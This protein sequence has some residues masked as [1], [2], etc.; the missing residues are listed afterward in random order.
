MG[1]S[2]KD[3]IRHSFL[4]RYG[5]VGWLIVLN[6]GVFVISGTIL[7][8]LSLMGK[9]VWFHAVYDKLALPSSI[10]LFLSQPWSLFTYMWMHDFGGSALGA[11]F[12]ILFNMLWLYWIGGRIFK[13]YQPDRRIWFLFIVGALVGGLLFMAAFN[14]FPAFDGRLALLVGASAGVTAIMVAT[15]T[16]LPNTTMFLMF[17]GA[18]KLVWLV[19]IFLFIDFLSIAASG[20]PGGMIAHLGGALFGYLYMTGVKNGKDIGAPIFRLFQK[21]QARP[22]KSPLRVAT[23]NASGTA[24][25]KGTPQGATAPGKPSQAEVDR[26]LDKIAKVGYEKL[27]Q[28]EKQI[29]YDASRE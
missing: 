4:P 13:Q 20:N 5:A 1:N 3:D 11:V 27:T 21:R 12:H 19:A 28:E 15:A 16:L 7:V 26:I 24:A 8:V 22:K 10:E 14:I 9:A 18:I 23:K 6:V 17:F 25:A 2:L 29:L